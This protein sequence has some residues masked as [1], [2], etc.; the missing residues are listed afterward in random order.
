[1][2]K[3]A[4]KDL[5]TYAHD[6]RASLVYIITNRKNG[7]RYVGVT[8]L[9]IDRRARTHITNATKGNPGKLY[10]AIRSH[11]ARWF[12][13]NVFT[14]CASY[15]DALKEERRLIGEIAPEYNLTAGGEGV[16]GHRFNAESKRR[17]SQSAKR[18]GPPWKRGECPDWVRDKLVASWKTRTYVKTDKLVVACR[19]NA[20]AANNGKRR[21][22]VSLTDGLAFP[23]TCHAGKF[24]NCCPVSIQNWAQGTKPR[25]RIDPQIRFVDEVYDL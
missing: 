8:R 6:N 4:Q 12:A 19:K 7:K 17:M 21:A 14:R 20:V 1:M 3:P 2:A 10:T 16:L 18:R 13:F 24:Y 23:S 9:S 22:V 15:K 25:G 5:F 11:G